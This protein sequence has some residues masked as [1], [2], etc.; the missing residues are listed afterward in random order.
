MK[1]VVHTMH[2]VTNRLRVADITNMK[3]HFTGKIGGVSLQVMTH[4]VLLFL[5][6]GE[7]ADFAHIGVEEM[8]ED[9]GAEGPRSSSNHEGLAL[10]RFTINH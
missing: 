7:D 8:L 1:D 4:V 6:A 2:G 9:G 5:I 10:E 3:T